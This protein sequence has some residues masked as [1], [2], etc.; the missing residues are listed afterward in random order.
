MLLAQQAHSQGSPSPTDWFTQQQPSLQPDTSTK[1]PQQQGGAARNP[2]KM[3]RDQLPSKSTLASSPLSSASSPPAQGMGGL[4]KLVG[5]S[6]AAAPSAAAAAGPSASPVIPARPDDDLHA[7]ERRMLEDIGYFRESGTGS[8]RNRPSVTVESLL[9]DKRETDRLAKARAKDEKIVHTLLPSPLLS[10]A[11]SSPQPPQLQ[12]PQAPPSD[13]SLITS[14]TARLSSLEKIANKQ[15]KTIGARDASIADLQ[16]QLRAARAVSSSVSAEEKT[17][18]SASAS[19][20][21]LYSLQQENEQYRRQVGEMETFLNDYG[22]V[23]VGF[24][25]GAGASNNTVSNASEDDAAATADGTASPATGSPGSGSLHSKAASSASSS[26]SEIFFDVPSFLSCVSELNSVAH[27][28]G[29]GALRIHTTPSGV[30]KFLP[31][32]SLD[33]VLYRD[34]MW[35]RGGPLRKW[36]TSAA[37]EF[38]RDVLEGFFPSELKAEYPEG[39]AIAVVDKSKERCL[40]AG[41]SGGASAGSVAGSATAAASDASGAA[42]DSSFQAFAGRGNRLEDGKLV[43]GSPSLASSPTFLRSP[44]PPPLLS[45]A[46]PPHIGVQS[47]LEKLPTAVVRNGRVIDVR[48]GVKAMLLPSQQSAAA[49]TGATAAATGNVSPSVSPT[50]ASSTAGSG[51]SSIVVDTPALRLIQARETALAALQSSSASASASS[52][53]ASSAAGGTAVSTPRTRRHAL[54]SLPP[55]P[56]I[57]TLQVKMDPSDLVRAPLLIKLLASDCIADLRAIVDAH[58]APGAPA[59]D[60]RSTYPARVYGESSNAETLASLGLT[61]NAN[62]FVRNRRP[63]SAYRERPPEQPK[64]DESWSTP[65]PE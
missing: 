63:L 39:V 11:S 38:V 4:Q 17:D 12:Q 34:G 54:D 42:K 43:D 15:A 45:S 61:P 48:E 31:P 10:S 16:M 2:V 60:L 28:G 6:A 13:M 23:W 22:L 5:G 8:S 58:R 35:F 14:L 55:L 33:L 49:A 64:P 41:S 7:I 37:Q 44:S 24:R 59:Y 32:L 25:A 26:S 51:S 47:F 20:E 40:A 65:A 27:E 21:L 3:P 30:T 52:A 56:P 57:A 29:Q 9:R 19:A 53:S 50:P 36:N 1:Q 18:G 62:L 46:A